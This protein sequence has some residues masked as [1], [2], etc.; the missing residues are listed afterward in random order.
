MRLTGSWQ[1]Y[2]RIASSS[3]VHPQYIPHE[4]S[5][6]KKAGSS[7]PHLLQTHSL[8]VVLEISSHLP[9]GQP[10]RAQTDE[11]VHDIL[12]LDATVVQHGK[13]L[14]DELGLLGGSEGHEGVDLG[15]CGRGFVVDCSS[16]EGGGV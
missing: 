15:R 2:H 8:V 9:R 16:V 7:K 13:G 14:F 6:S 10:V 4:P 1:S 5:S 11:P 12:I 3:I